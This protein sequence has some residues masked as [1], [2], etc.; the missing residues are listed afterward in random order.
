MTWKV[1]GRNAWK[2]IANLQIEVLSTCTKSHVLPSISS[3][4]KN[5]KRWKLSN[6]LLAN[7]LRMPIF[8]TNWLVDL[9]DVPWSL[10]KLA[11][12][13]HNMDKK[14]LVTNVWLVW[15]LTLTTWVT[16]DNIATRDV[17]HSNADWYCPKTQTLLGTLKI[18]NQLRGDFFC[19]FGTRKFVPKSGMFKKQTSVSHSSTESEVISLD[20]GFRMDGIPAL[21]L[22]DLVIEVLQ[23]FV[24]KK[25]VRRNPWRDETQSKHTNTKTEMILKILCGSRHHK[26]K[27]YSLRSHALLEDNKAVIKIIIEGRIL[28][29]RHVS[30]TDRVAFGWLFDRINWDTKIQNQIC[31]HQKPNRR[32]I[33]ERQLHPWWVKSSSSC[34][35]HHE[36]FSMFSC[37]HFS[38]I[39]NSQ[40]M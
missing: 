40:T 21:D 33:D 19:I 38:P 13:S 24:F 6:I 30:R 7:G 22:W 35:Q 31:R 15:H 28:T 2:D 16:T 39:N 4:R 1:V 10:N 20:A 11:A 17:Q 8:G 26:R 23:S 32:P 34:V 3:E 12:S 25:T 9:I 36:F 5:W 14:E 29:M 27:T 37:S 18:R